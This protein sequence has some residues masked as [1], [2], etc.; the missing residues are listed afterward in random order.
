MEDF[1]APLP[2][3]NINGKP[4]ASCHITIP[5]RG[6]LCGCCRQ[7]KKRVI[8]RQMKRD[9]QDELR[10]IEDESEKLHLDTEYTEK[11]VV[12]MNILENNKKR[13]RLAHRFRAK[14]TY[15]TRDVHTIIMDS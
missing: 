7:K 2:A 8:D 3:Y 11:W 1:N 12:A 6:V 15:Q 9:R 10:R 13:N 14:G 4:C 5:K